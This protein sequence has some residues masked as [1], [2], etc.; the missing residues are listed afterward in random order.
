M[1]RYREAAMTYEARHAKSLNYGLAVAVALLSI[2]GFAVA[3]VIPTESG[4]SPLVGW[5]IVTACLG[6]AFIFIRRARDDAPQ[7]RI[8]ENGVWSRKTGPDT[9][10]WSEVSHF[11]LMRA[12]I[13]RIG[14]FTRTAAKR[15]ASTQLSMIAASATSL[16]PCAITGLTSPDR[17][18][19]IER[20][21]FTALEPAAV[22][23]LSA[24][25]VALLEPAFHIRAFA[26]CA[27]SR[28]ERFISALR[29]SLC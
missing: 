1:A 19:R 13:Q 16:Q 6:A 24:N 21:P 12:G 25:D 18:S 20:A 7:A 26:D 10:P 4:S 3:G 14:R 27:R 8:D 28:S 9:T 15:S 17:K 22:M 23:I 5:A 2:L 29:I 11:Y